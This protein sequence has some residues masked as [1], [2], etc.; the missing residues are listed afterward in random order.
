MSQ[1]VITHIEF[2]GPC[3]AREVEEEAPSIWRKVL[4]AVGV[5]ITVILVVALTIIFLA[6]SPES[7]LQPF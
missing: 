7:L 1:K 4:K 3:H 2:P 5:I 6:V